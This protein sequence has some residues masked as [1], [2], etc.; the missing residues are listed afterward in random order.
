MART[1]AAM[2]L[3]ARVGRHTKLGGRHCQNWAQDQQ[4]IIDLLNRIPI[5]DGGAGGKLNGRIIVGMSSQALYQAIS[6]FEDRHFPG[7]RSGFVDPG[8]AMLKRMEEL[9]ARATNGPA[10]T[11]PAAKPK[12]LDVLRRNVLDARAVT[13]KWPSGDQV[14][15]DPLVSMVVKHVDSLKSQ[16]FDN[17]PYA[18][19]WGRA[20]VIDMGAPDAPVT[21]ESRLG[22]YNING[23]PRL[24]YTDKVG[25]FIKPDLPEMSYGGPLP[26][27]PRIVIVTT[28]LGA[29]LLFEDGTCF[30]L[31]PK[32]I[33]RLDYI[34]DLARKG[35]FAD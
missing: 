32:R 29:M 12:P 23:T 30:R 14:Q 24:G 34:M 25:R 27:K 18:E 15:F 2:S 33:R 1:E 13:G 11:Q 21:V 4:T 22:L 26:I 5:A 9:A 35:I 20:H 28:F 31:G 3:R 6:Q 16:G 8:G 10:A 19:L 17:I 7:Q